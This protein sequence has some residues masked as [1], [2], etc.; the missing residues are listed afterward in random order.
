MLVGL[1]ICSCDVECNLHTANQSVIVILCGEMP[2]VGLA[3]PP[4]A[5]QLLAMEHGSLKNG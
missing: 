2:L 5:I 1:E 4:N 3:L